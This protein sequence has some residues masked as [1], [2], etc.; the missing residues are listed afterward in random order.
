MLRR[1]LGC[2][3]QTK[4]IGIELTVKLGFRHFF[5]RFEVVNSGVVNQDVDLAECFFPSAKRRRCL[6]SSRRRP[7]RLSPFP[8]LANFVNYLVC[9]V[10]GRCIIDHHSRALRGEMFSIPAPI[11]FDA[12]VTTATFPLV[13]R[14]S[15]CFLS[16]SF[17]TEVAGQ[18]EETAVRS[19]VGQR[20]ELCARL[21][22]FADFHCRVR[23]A[24]LGL[25]PA[26][27]RGVRFDFVVAQFVGEM[28]RE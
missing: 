15:C 25:H 10:L 13:F 2:E 23:A 21:P 8:P 18:M 28:H 27:M 17:T 14:F 3:N 26:G 6:F 22:T 9:T 20:S 1:L 19:V 5:K 4:N 24:H 7:E 12:P 16:F 11:P